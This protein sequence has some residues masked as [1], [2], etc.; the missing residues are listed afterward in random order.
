MYQSF[1]S[2]KLNYLDFFFKTADGLGGKGRSD[3]RKYVE[4]KNIGKS[5]GDTFPEKG[6]YFGCISEK[7]EI[8]EHIRTFVLLYFQVMNR[9][10]LMIVGS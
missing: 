10:T 2:D 8:E 5:N 4:R 1:N 6:A 3:K 9:K 7:E